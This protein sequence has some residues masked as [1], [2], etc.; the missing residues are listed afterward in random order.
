MSYQELLENVQ[1][2]IQELHVIENLSVYTAAYKVVSLTK[3]T[4]R[5]GHYSLII[6]NSRESSI[7][8]KAYGAN[9][10]EAATKKYLELERKHFGDNQV[11][12][13]LVNTGDVKKLELSYP[14]YFMDT[15]EL[16][17][18]LSLIMMGK[19]L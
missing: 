5:K 8:L 3:G 9:Q 7:S 14:N 18:N 6:L 19:F 2:V 13:V 16:V 17:Q 1:K 15:K 11:N 4:G 10:L 12:V